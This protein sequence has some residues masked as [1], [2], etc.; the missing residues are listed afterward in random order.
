[1][2]MPWRRPICSSGWWPMPK[3]PLVAFQ[4]R[5]GRGKPPSGQ[6]CSPGA[7]AM[8]MGS[9]PGIQEALAAG[10]IADCAAMASL[11]PPCA[12]PRLRGSTEQRPLPMT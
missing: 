3:R 11:L 12:A 5:N 4:L 9:R 7:R 8:E 6:T 1:M 2:P 10:G